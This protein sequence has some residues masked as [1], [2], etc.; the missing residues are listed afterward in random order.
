MK[1][2]YRIIIALSAIIGIAIM[3]YLTYLH[4]SG[5]GGSFC[6]LVAGLSCDIVNKS[7]YAEILGIPFSILGILYFI[8]VLW[9]VWRR[10]DIFTLKTIIILSIIFLGPSLY[11]TAIEIFVIINI[12][13]FCEISKGLMFV[14]IGASYLAMRH[15]PPKISAIAGALAAAILLAGFI[16]LIHA[17][18]GP[19]EKYDEFAQ[20]L[21]EKGFIM[22]GSITCSACARQR[23]MFGDSF[24]FIKE[25][26][27]DPRNPN[28]ETQRC[29]EKNIKG[30][31]TWI[32]ENA[33]GN[34]LHRFDTG[35]QSLEKLS[36]VSNCPLPT[37]K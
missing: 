5:G 7:I 35:L 36:S 24:K 28:P 27:C 17:N 14:I 13:V 33:N 8:G 25:I 16:Y 11:L 19:G 18:V 4:Y 22:Y 1:K 32:Q 15:I 23:A 34:E 12:C 9:A 30:T 37:K 31:P 6:N 2:I 21:D 26:E 20:C 10:Y 29:I 3:S